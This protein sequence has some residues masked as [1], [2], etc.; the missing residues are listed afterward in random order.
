MS[1]SARQ[2]VVSL[3]DSLREREAQARTARAAYRASMA[4]VATPDSMLYWLTAACKEAREAVGRKQV[5]IAASLEGGR[6]RFEQGDGWRWETDALVAAYERLC[7]LPAGE[8]W[9]RAVDSE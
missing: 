9:R 1:T 8:L 2:P 4:P 6:D 3:F 7:G 5:H